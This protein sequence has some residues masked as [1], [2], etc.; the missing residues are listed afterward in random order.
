[1]SIFGNIMSSIFGHA[2]AQTTQA[3]PG[4]SGKTSGPAPSSAGGKK[5]SP[6]TTGAGSTAYA[7]APTTA[8]PEVDVEA[9][10]AQL[11]SQNKEK[12]DWRKSIV[13]LMKL[14]KLDSGLSTRKELA[15]ELHYTGDTNDTAAMNVWLHKQVMVKLAENG[16]KV[17]GS[18]KV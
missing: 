9:V 17:P 14:L 5:S 16:G 6:E 3:A 4:A 18:L 8:Q 2:K 15:K 10:L 13:D 7:T 1:M 12:L 11:A